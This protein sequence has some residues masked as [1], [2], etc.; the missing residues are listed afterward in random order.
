MKLKALHIRNIA[1]IERA[2][3]DFEHGLNDAVTGEPAPIFLIAGDTG[4]GKS[5]ILDSI[6]MALYK[7]TPRTADVANATRNDYTDAEGE[8][9]RVASIEQYTRL[10]ISEKDESYSEVVF[11]GND[12]VGYRARLT[13]GMK[14][15]TKDK[16]T[17]LRPLKHRSPKWEI[18]VGDGD[19][20]KD[21]VEQTV[22]RAVG[23][24]FQQFGRMAMLAQGQFANFLTGDKKEREAILEQLTNTQHFTTYGEAIQSLY[25]KA[26]E[27]QMLIQ[28]QYDTE[29]PHTL[30]DEEVAQIIS[31]R[32]TLL[33]QKTALDHQLKLIEDRQK[34]TATVLDNERRQ[35]EAQAQAEQLRAIIGG[36]D[37]RQRKALFTDWD[38]TTTQRHELANQLKAM[39]EVQGA[40][41]ELAQSSE[42]FSRLAAD[43]AD[44]QAK[45]AILDA[46]IQENRRWME[47]RRPFANLFSKAGETELK[48]GQYV[49]KMAKTRDLDRLLTAERAKTEALQSGLNAAARE[50]LEATMAVKAKETEI[51][52]LSR[53]R[54]ALHPEDTLSLMTQKEGARHAMEDLRKACNNLVRE[55]AE[56]DALRQE[57]V[58][59]K[60]RLQAL[61]TAKDE[62]EKTFQARKND[63][64]QAEKRLNTMRMSINDTIVTLRH[65]LAEE[66]T[67]TCPLCGQTIGHTHLSDDFKGVLTPLEAEQQQA[68]AA[69]NQ[70][71]ALRDKA[72]D[73]YVKA[74]SALQHQA[75]QLAGADEKNAQA[76]KA[77]E[78]TARQLGLLIGLPLLPQIDEALQLLAADMAR[79][80]TAQQQAEQLQAQVNVLLKEK[81]PLDDRKLKA[82]TARTQA[83]NDV[84]R[85]AENIVRIENEL[86]AHGA[87]GEALKTEISFLLAGYA[88]HWLTDTDAVR[89]LLKADAE[90]Y[91][92]H[93][94]QLNDDLVRQERDATLMASLRQCR[95][96][97]VQACPQWHPTGA[98]AAYPC[99][100]ILAEWTALLARVTEL[101]GKV[102]D[103]RQT[104]AAT[105]EA[106][107]AYCQ[108]TGT[109]CHALQTLMGR[110]SEVTEARRF[111]SETDSQLKSRTDAIADAQRQT[112][113]ALQALGISH[114]DALSTPQQLAEERLTV[115]TQRDDVLSRIAQAQSRL[116]AH[117]KN[118]AHLRQT[119]ARLAQARQQFQRWDR[120]NSIFGGT[121]FRTLVQTYILR[122][123]LNNANVYLEQITDRYQLTC[124]ED[125]EQLSILV[126]DRYNKNQVR[127][128]TVLS[129]GECFIV[130]LALSLALSS[131]NRP[132]MNVN[133]LFIDEGFGTLDE[134]SLDSVMSTLEKLQQIAGQ[135]NRRV[136]IISHREELEE[137]IP[138]QIQVVK[139][140]EGRSIIQRG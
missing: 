80:K 69:L 139:K 123:L 30:T 59:E 129:G 15:G 1:S 39:Q 108:A 66:H 64:E 4:A 118:I 138:V 128:A 81:K 82:E 131:L 62:A 113:S 45:T 65:R 17:G 9:I 133:I 130:S 52:R 40:E 35:Q 43:M 105:T 14:L 2:D 51:E 38:A 93:Q 95:Q 41:A 107:T 47:Q 74:E 29:K 61:H 136:G 110:E 56:A 106:L 60:E 58:R 104:I 79:L 121:R 34:L 20:T 26:K 21:S 63:D 55:R 8:S 46:A 23:L 54:E 24:D 37:Y 132:D 90:A 119:E 44:R 88:D 22:L 92:T 115:S 103:Y 84:R 140:G 77:I 25:K 3:I 71:T 89:R 16:T 91:A 72:R 137:R 94:K 127:S 50:A 83:D 78:A 10:G 31:D 112:D 12:G 101:V 33:E 86:Q 120:L 57:T 68:K 32:Q 36:E 100:D 99:R 125:N 114:R 49:A 102:R 53:Q 13:L 116:E 76:Q 126:L 109:T 135:T 11:E 117:H 98:P 6:S 111:V 18:R 42:R 28:T 70:A 87:D 73:A 27:T 7:K 96:G 85:N 67:P 5:V 124:S 134:R 97:I 75:K 48:M 122:P 19:W